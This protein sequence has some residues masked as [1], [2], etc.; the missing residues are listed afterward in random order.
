MA[1]KKEASQKP[2]WFYAVLSITALIALVLIV[3]FSPAMPTGAV[4]AAGLSE[5]YD[6]CLRESYVYEPVA[7]KGDREIS[8][9]THLVKRFDLD[10]ARACRREN[11]PGKYERESDVYDSKY[12]IVDYNK[13]NSREIKAQH[14]TLWE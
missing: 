5:T 1:G 7:L 9:R 10:Q 2:V 12:I 8:G 11:W 6:K 3:F 13:G 14:N 4:S